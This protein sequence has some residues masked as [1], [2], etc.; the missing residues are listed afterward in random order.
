MLQR[1]KRVS[2]TQNQP[3]QK[4]KLLT[5]SCFPK[6]GYRIELNTPNKSEFRSYRT[7]SARAVCLSKKGASPWI[8]L[9]LVSAK[10]NDFERFALEKTI[11]FWRQYLKVFPSRLGEIMKKVLQP[12]KAGPI[13]N[14]HNVLSKIGQVVG[15]GT[16]LDTKYMGLVQWTKCSKTHLKHVIRTHWNAS[17]CSYLT[18]LPRKSFSCAATGTDGFHRATHKLSTVDLQIIKTHCCGTNYTNDIKSKY[19]N[20]PNK[21][22]L[23]DD[24]D[25]K[26]HRLFH[27]P[28]L[29]DERSKMSQDTI[30]LGTDTGQFCITSNKWRDFGNTQELIIWG[31][32]AG[33]QCFPSW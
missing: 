5:M 8:A 14:L 7:A 15:D 18:N 17:V 9:N 21:C 16:M 4:Q 3:K 26:Q 22:P 1:C 10:S 12:P 23:C 20:T 32:C 2:Q 33:C 29:A 25:S 6:A 30:N 24:A 11:L 13:T 19:L 27:C 28:F 31:F